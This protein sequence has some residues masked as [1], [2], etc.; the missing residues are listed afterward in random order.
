ME[1]TVYQINLFFG[2]EGS[3][4]QAMALQQH[5]APVVRRP[6]GRDL[7]CCIHGI[8]WDFTMENRDFRMAKWDFT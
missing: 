1:N 4:L 5:G 3:I 8:S 2:H 7:Q 6:A